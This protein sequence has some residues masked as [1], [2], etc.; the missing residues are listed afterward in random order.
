MA[1]V[2]GEGG[3]TLSLNL[4]PMLDIFSI[5]VTFLLMSY[6]TDPVNH[7]IDQNLELPQSATLAS[8]DEVPVVTVTTKEIRINDKFVVAI[9]GGDVPPDAIAQ[10]AI[11]PVYEKLQKITDS[12][13]KMLARLGAE[14]KAKLNA[15]T[16]EM[17]QGHSS[18]LLKRIM[19][20]AEQAEFI[21][22]KLLVAKTN[23]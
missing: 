4:T 15:L 20:S 2:G 3:D 23:G 9:A 22:F 13:R 21:K 5:L 14:E 17:D 19:L 1:S 12:N 8:L 11:M 18:K 10:G 16:M 7:D 6:S